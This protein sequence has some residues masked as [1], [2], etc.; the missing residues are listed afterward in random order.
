MPKSY[1]RLQSDAGGS[2]LSDT[3][4]DTPVP[5]AM[6]ALPDPNPLSFAIPPKDL[7]SEGISLYFQY[8]HKQPLWLFDMDGPFIP[9]NHRS[10]VILS[11][12]SLALRYSNNILLDGRIDQICRQY[13][14]SACSSVMLRI[15]QG[16]VDLSTLQS[17]CLIALAE[18][19][20]EKTH[21]YSALTVT[22]ANC[23]SLLSANQNHLAWLHIGLVTNLAR[24]S[25]LDQE[26]HEGDLTLA[27]EERRR[28]LWSIYLLN[29]QYAPHNM[30]L[31]MLHDIQNPKYMA[32]AMDPSREMGIKP[33]QT[34]QET[35]IFSRRGG[36]WVY[37]VQMSGLWN[38]VQHF[39]SHCASGDTTPPWS[40]QSGYSMIGAHLMDM[41]T[42][43]PTAHRYDSARFQDQPAE[44]LHR[45]RPYWSP[46]L[47]LQ[48][49]Y[50]AVHSVINHP[51]LYS[52]RPQDSPQRAV[53]NT[54][55]KTSS[56]LAL[57]HSTWIVHLIGMISEKN[58]KLS[59]P[60]LGHTVAIAATIHIYYCRAADQT[61][62]ESAQRK[63]ETCTDFLSDLASQWPRF[64]EIVSLHPKEFVSDT[65]S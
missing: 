46:W 35:G 60:F 45:D 32:P 62:R 19:T 49:V 55:W 25:G 23:L 31:N 44:E 33:P 41:E 36:I 3:A 47:Y 18:Y 24:C 27:L 21:F 13:V 42:N 28:V 39:V 54:F 63:L 6:P 17:L 11:M 65:C 64:Q 22:L 12:L 5:Y 16:S 9:E 10:E 14:D 2:E 37:M 59:D 20:G 51:F 8:C 15:S 52:W 50:H 30:Q 40:V 7:V 58:Y 34:P 26:S 61:V 53:P 57:V 43:Y 29:Q 4:R 38:E 48:L 56:E 1:S